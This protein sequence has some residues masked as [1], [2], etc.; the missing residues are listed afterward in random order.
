M[1]RNRLYYR[2]KPVLPHK[3]RLSIR[4]W[5][6]LRKRERVRDIWPIAPGSEQPPQN[7]PGWP[8]GKKFALVL[9]H[10]VEGAGGLDRCRQLMKLEKNLGF[11]SSFNFIPKGGY[12][13]PEQLR[14]ELVR[15]GFEVG[16]HDLRHDGK[17]YRTRKDFSQNAALIN[18]YLRDWNA[19]GFRSG[20]MLHNLNWL[21]DLNIEYDASTFDTD[22]FEPQPDHRNTIFPFW[23]SAPGAEG[24]GSPSGRGGYVELPYTLPQDSTMFL[25]FREKTPELW[26][27]KLDWIAQHGGMVLLNTHPDYMNFQNE[28]SAREFP[29]ARYQEFLEYVQSKYKDL[30]WHATPREVASY[31]R[32]DV[33]SVK[34]SSYIPGINS[35]QVNAK[36]W[37]DLDNTPH[38]PFFEPIIREFRARGFEV[39]CT[40]R[41][42]FQV[43]DLARQRGIAFQQVGRHSG[44][45]RIRKA[46]GLFYRAMQLLPIAFREKPA[47]AISHGSRA[48]IL[49][50]KLL[51]IPTVLI[52][53]YEHAAYPP[54]M[55]PRWEIVPDTIG[56]Q[57]LCCAP[58][59]ARRYPGLKEHVYVRDFRP[60]ASVLGELGLQEQQL[61]VTVRPPA[62]EAHYH[63]DRGEAL[64]FDLMDFLLRDPRVRVVLMPRNKKQAEWMQQSKPK[65]FADA[66]VIVPRGPM[67]GLNVIFHSDLVVS[68]GGTM[69]REAAALGVPAYSILCGKVGA[70]DR[71]L[72]RGGQLTLVD[73]AQDFA[74]KIKLVRRP[75]PL[76]VPAQAAGA[77]ESIMS[78]IEEILCL[79]YAV[80]SIHRTIPAASRPQPGKIRTA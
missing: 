76:T 5:F 77:F 10:D 62:T 51:N 52:E 49:A 67:N 13:V 22:P 39:L 48:Q 19:V 8:G 75:R 50:C 41:D 38:V 32:A 72:E 7:W 63:N 28:N 14:N 12:E 18:E 73:S 46:I 11:R 74:E 57:G 80:G 33:R 6:A 54:S 15:N 30:Y 47:L 44:K 9:T 26:L 70:V 53:D 20:F 25:L 36:V 24:S 65:W 58:D 60:D 78:H 23:I 45:N 16:V 68:G 34:S 64:F 42:A 79:E 29:V 17:L 43:C 55:R 69:N 59:H 3:L 2:I 37:I 1:F 31:V 66:R 35:E 40:A 27:R 56:D 21:H 71:A 61:I 4:R